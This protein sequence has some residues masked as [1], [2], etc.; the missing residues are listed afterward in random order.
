[1][2]FWFSS[3][4]ELFWQ[5]HNPLTFIYCDL[6][7][8][9]FG[10]VA[11]ARFRCVSTDQNLPKLGRPYGPRTIPWQDLHGAQSDPVTILC[12]RWRRKWLKHGHERCYLMICGHT[13]TL[14]LSL[15]LSVSLPFPP[16]FALCLFWSFPLFLSLLL[17]LFLTLSL[18]RKHSYI[19]ALFFWQG[20]VVRD[21]SQ[22]V[23]ERYCWYLFNKSIVFG[24]IIFK[25]KYIQTHSLMA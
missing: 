3:S 23:D 15:S 5:G 10:F 9:R 19:H 1:M 6:D 20:G 2:S 21:R 7:G 4:L 8:L 14:V 16:F 25:H 24:I 13:H 12:L 22:S 18:K 17:A 11:S